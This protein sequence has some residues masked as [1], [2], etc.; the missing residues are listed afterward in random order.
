ME[1]RRNVSKHFIAGAFSS[2]NAAFGFQTEANPFE[3][4]HT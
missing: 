4:T 2:A 3:V 1:A